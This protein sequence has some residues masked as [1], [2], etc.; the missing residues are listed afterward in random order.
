MGSICELLAF[1]I[2]IIKMLTTPTTTFIIQRI[3]FMLTIVLRG[4]SREV[5]GR[6]PHMSAGFT[7]ARQRRQRATIRFVGPSQDPTILVD[8]YREHQRYHYGRH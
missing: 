4:S 3:F 5:C 6:I 1:G 2:E 7:Q 8:Q